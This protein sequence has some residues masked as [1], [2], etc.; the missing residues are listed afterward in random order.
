[1]GF[2]YLIVAILTAIIVVFAFQNP[3]PVS[4][5]FLAW[6]VPEVSAAAVILLALATGLVIAAIP[7]MIQRWRLRFR[8][9]ALQNQVEQLEAALARRPS[10]ATPPPASESR[11]AL[12]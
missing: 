3:T 5:K 1:M 11:Q 7:L 4:V 10:A 12:P 8:V 2:G 9:R 6:T